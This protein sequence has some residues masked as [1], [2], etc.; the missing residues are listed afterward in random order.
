VLVF[1]SCVRAAST[2]S[3]GRKG[4]GRDQTLVPIDLLA[5]DQSLYSDLTL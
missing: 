1:V 5:S 3:W 4:L 2:H